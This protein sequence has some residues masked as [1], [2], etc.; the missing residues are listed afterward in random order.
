MDLPLRRINLRIL[1]NPSESFD[2]LPPFHPLTSIKCLLLKVDVEISIFKR[3]F[4]Y[5]M[6]YVVITSI[7]F[8]ATAIIDTFFTGDIGKVRLLF[9]R[10]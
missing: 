8:G 7:A 10:Q 9:T 3:Y 4:S 1:Q 6:A 2:R 5:Y